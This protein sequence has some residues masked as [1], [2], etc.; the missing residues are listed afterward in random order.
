MSNDLTL[1]F[2]KNLERKRI[3]V[4]KKVFS[5]MELVEKFTHTELSVVERKQLGEELNQ[6]TSEIIS[7]CINQMLNPSSRSRHLQGA[8][9]NS[10]EDDILFANLL[11]L[12]DREVS[13]TRIPAPMAISSNEVSLTLEI[14][15]LFLWGGILGDISKSYSQEQIDRSLVSNDCE[16]AT[17]YTKQ[18][19]S[20]LVH[21]ALH[22]VYD[23][24]AMYSVEMKRGKHYAEIANIA[25][26]C[27]INQLLSHIPEGTVTLDH[28]RELSDNPDL[29]P[30]DLS[31]NYYHSLLENN[32]TPEQFEE[33]KVSMGFSSEEGDGTGSNSFSQEAL[34]G[35]LGDIEEQLSG[36]SPEDLEKFGNSLQERYDN[37]QQWGESSEGKETS[38]ELVSSISRN[39]LENAVENYLEQRG[40][41]YAKN[42]GTLS[43]SMQ[44]IV[45]EIRE[46]SSLDWK[47][48][49]TQMIG[50]LAV[51]YR[52]TKNRVNRRQPYAPHLRGKIYDRLVK[53]TFA[54]DTSGSMSPKDISYCLNELFS[55]LEA[56]PFELNVIE[57]DS[58]IKKTYTINDSEDIQYSVSGRGGTSYQ[59]LFNYLGEKEYKD[60]EDVLI[61]ATDGGGMET[62]LDTKYFHNVMWMLIGGTELSVKEPVGVVY[63]LD[64]DKEFKEWKRNE[65]KSIN[66]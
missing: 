29:L 33:N 36:M 14:N 59:P 55:I 58:T 6:T 22:V 39:I 16:S 11:M 46:K 52:L 4:N 7:Y 25:M 32:K 54:I 48:I 28:V 60:S 49:L 37:H 5:C 62:E 45:D 21:E 57:F 3:S 26:D 31:R 15:P 19:V 44:S 2:L 61:V 38:E 40:N 27:T 1:D 8:I 12:L 24:I 65:R 10:N 20:I 43:R 53:V 47:Q 9:E 13:L 56:Y 50:T 34:E 63:Q 35:L 17:F 51:P 41:A 66:N 23:H 42:A 30:N 64:L 18:I